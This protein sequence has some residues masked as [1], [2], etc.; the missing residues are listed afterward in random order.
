MVPEFFLHRRDS[1]GSIS[2]SYLL[3]LWFSVQLTFSDPI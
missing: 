1:R 3:P 2:V